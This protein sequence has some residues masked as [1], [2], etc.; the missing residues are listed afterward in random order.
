MSN[1]R[2]L[3]VGSDGSVLVGRYRK[4]ESIEYFALVRGEQRIFV[5]KIDGQIYTVAVTGRSSPIDVFADL[6][7]S[8]VPVQTLESLRVAGNVEGAIQHLADDP[9]LA[10]W[11]LLV[12]SEMERAVAVPQSSDN[13]FVLEI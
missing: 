8:G 5:R 9:F 11:S 4:P 10:E 12:Q 1:N 2:D 7:V 3:Q 13:A 6:A